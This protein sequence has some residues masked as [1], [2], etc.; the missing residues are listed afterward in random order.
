[1]KPPCPKGGRKKEEGRSNVGTRNAHL[2]PDS[3]FPIPYSPSP[4]P[5]S[6]FFIPHY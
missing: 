6:L 2:I 5:D 1:M 4:I 3:R